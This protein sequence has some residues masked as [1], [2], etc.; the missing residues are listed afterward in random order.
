[1]GRPC[2][3]ELS[4]YVLE[5]LREGRIFALYRGRQPGNAV[6]ILL[7]APVSAHQTPSAFGQLEHEL[8]LAQD[9]D[10]AWAARPLALVSHDG[11]RM[12][13]LEDPGGEPLDGILGQPLELTR[14]LK[15]AI[16]LAA[17]LRQL[18]GRGLVHKDIKPENL[19]VDAAGNVRLTGFGIASRL[20]R[21]RQVPSP[22]QII[23]GSF[24]YMAP[25]QTGRMNRSIDA[26]SDLYSLGITSY[27]MLTGVLPFTA[28]D[29]MEWVHCHIA[30]QPMPPGER[31]AGIPSQVAA[32][33]LKLLAKT[34][35]ERYQTAGGLEADLRQCLA[36]WQAEGRIDPFPL[37]RRDVSDR[38]LIPEKLYGREAEIG[39]LLAAFDRVVGHGATELVL[40]S[41]YSGIGKSSLVNEL[42]K[43]LVPARGLFAAGKFDQYKRNIPY[44]TLAQAFHSLVHQIL[45]KSDS[46]MSA[47]RSA[48]L[49]ALGPN[50]QLM[51]NL[52][53][54]LALI[55]GEQMPVAD[56]PPQD[57][58]NRFQLVFR[59]FL[60]VFARA[61]HPLVLFLDDLQWLDTA[62]LDL[63]EHLVTHPEV[64][65]LLLIGA[66][67]DNEVISSHP[68]ARMVAVIRD[69]GARLQEIMLAPLLAEDVERLLTDALHAEPGR[70]APLAE[71]V[72]EKTA[73]NPFFTIQFLTALAEE[74]LLTFGSGPAGDPGI[75]G[76]SWDLPRI[77]AKGFTDNVV[78]L[79]AAKLSRLPLATQKTLGQ[80]ACLG[81]PAETATLTLVHG[82][83]EE[84]IHASLWE[85]VRAGLV[86]RADATYS[87]LHDRIQEA[88]YALIPQGERVM[89]HLRIGRLLA[90]R[91][92]AG[93]LEE[94]I[95]DIVSQFDR[96][97]A[98][99]TAAAEREQ[100]ARLNLMAG[101][102]AK[103]ATAYAAAL[104]YFSAGRMLL[105]E[106]R[107]ERC[108]Q[109]AFDLELN[110]A[111]CVYLTGELVAAEKRLTAVSARARTIVD[112]A[113]VTCV[114][115]NL[116]TN[117]DQSDNAVAVG[118]EYLQRLDD[119][120]SSQTTEEDV[121]REYTRLWQRLGSDPIEALLDLPLMSD[122]D[123]RA[124]MDVLTVLTTP[125]LFTNL[126][127][128]RLVVFRM[129]AF[130]LK[131]GNTDGSCLAYVWLGGILGRYFGDY[132]AGLRFGELGLDLVDNRGLDRL[133]ARVYLGFAVHV[134]HWSQPL[135]AC[136]VFLRRAFE[137]ARE[138]GDLTYAAY[139]C[140]DLISNL[141]TAGAP[142]GEIEREAKNALEFV[143]NVRF[144]LIG[145]TIAG[146]YRLIRT[147]R[148][149]TPDFSSFDDAEF[150][151]S[152]IE[153][154]LESNPR[155]AVAASRYW[156]R[157]LQASVYAGD[158][159]SGV[160]VASKAASL[161]WTLPTQI[162][163]PD[164]HFY[165]ALARAGCC[166]TT[167][168]EE[169]SGHLEALAAHHGQIVVWAESGPENFAD[170]A[171]LLG[172]EMA[173]LE[174]RELDA[175]G[176]YEEA[177]RLAREHGFVQ[178][179]GLAN[180]LAARFHARRGFET[181]AQAYLGQARSCY[182][183]WGAEGKVRQL[184]RLHPYLRQ[185]P[186]TARGDST[187]LTSVEQLDLA[188]VVKVSQAVS[189]EIDLRKLIDTLMVIALRNAGADR[190]LLIL[191]V[192]DELRIEAEAITIRDK[193][194]VWFR[195][196]PLGPA[197]LPESV[198]RYVVRTRESLLLDDAAEQN[199][200]SGDDYIRQSRCRSILCLPLIKQAKLAGALYLENSLASHVFTPARI[201]VLGLLASQAAISLENASLY[202][203]LQHAQAFL[204]EA[205]RLSHTGSFIY[206][207]VSEE[208]YW[209]DEVFRIY[210]FEPAGTTT[211]DKLLQRVH[212]E[213][214]EK[215]MHFVETTPRDGREHQLEH[216]LLMPD[217]LV[218]T[219][220]IVMHARTN[221]L[222]Q[223]EFLGTAMD[224]TA[225]KQTQGRLQ[226]SLEEKDALLKEVHH[227]V[228][229]NLQLISS[230]LSLQ[231]A[232]IADPQVAEL[233]A[234]SR[235][236]VRSMAL[237]HENLY[238]AGNFARVPMRT[239][240]QNLAAHLIRAY[241][242]QGQKI[243]LSTEIDDIELDLDRAVSTGLIINELISNA[244][245]HAF[246]AGRPG[247]VRVGL[248]LVDGKQCLLEVSDDGI[249]LS[250]DFEVERAAG[251]GLQLVHDLTRQLQGTIAV[252][253]GS[254]TR[255]AIAFGADGA[256]D[257]AR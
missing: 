170:R 29:P 224:V 11:R 142:L 230:L 252:Q 14:F 66:Y 40:V 61:G 26:R 45:G 209:S 43:A 13:A 7:L 35:E 91:T 251:L 164:Y 143:R 141:L 62:T 1:M 127:F 233:F 88:A 28:A 138:A 173:R 235:N 223:V 165:A 239:H 186:A 188:T 226:A 187:S 242:L 55:I 20:P 81:N 34:A 246:P 206:N 110:R 102:R 179:E 225:F 108:Y 37:G 176:L 107:W 195:R 159:A 125:A 5:T 99:I 218:K 96:G 84:A 85:A 221:E 74:A 72:F 189:G 54:E 253:R 75:S 249:G 162:E 128:F 47:W 236:R 9:L 177:I 90:A 8:A 65:H 124:T 161:L 58:Q 174:G 33:V 4:G 213:D 82:G 15:L 133:R 144:G 80:L 146:Q 112:S 217:G 237:V 64:R 32:I 23:A 167:P 38:L 41:G 67:R 172:A 103:A 16:A 240:I 30:R 148:G 145:D 182:L 98:L 18:H 63:I 77:H 196:L 113:A 111:E 59:R 158:H 83:S 95:F 27:E 229:N 137:A 205:Q 50:G 94:K 171:A 198:L 44:A 210:G 197:E 132:Q 115:I 68:L 19:L 193:V 139:S 6:S 181:V 152:R 160:A 118:L 192:G 202:A 166:D 12:L 49:D 168:A 25:E 122:P 220:H 216:R 256:A 105:A 204:A 215:V 31:V 129:A 78:D 185:E 255:F 212:P 183:R 126:N 208:I 219:L 114:R 101:K 178:N 163:L 254:G 100:V 131:H 69:A 203:N 123:R 232:R 135:A 238:R 21:E 52:I 184:D 36:A 150:D 104:Q 17:A 71:L 231:A 116:Y 48:L 51:V 156:I 87:F 250:T 191:A 121:Q 247:Q 211:L 24:A 86:R 53:P 234:E 97:A 140:S 89:A 93:E 241:D 222:G 76:W 57:R 147:L 46:E 243:G 175:M 117:L 42:H 257:A 60:G 106:N 153:Q 3:T 228:K 73:G 155:L 136:R 157:K 92:A 227:R 214:R 190:G 79:M 149:L 70:A 109:L 22:P 39:A 120:W 207:T 248:K 194:E 244:L 154:R 180:E 10:S 119:T 199:P 130:S 201:A 245:K 56:L 2:V 134:A 200:F 169:R 151:D